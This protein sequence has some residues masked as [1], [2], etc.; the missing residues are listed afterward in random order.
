MGGKAQRVQGT[1]ETRVYTR[2]G[3]D[4]PDADIR[5]SLA[6]REKRRKFALPFDP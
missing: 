1:L 5:D 4:Q 6:T 2:A 3:S